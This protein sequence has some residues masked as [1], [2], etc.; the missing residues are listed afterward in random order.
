MKK[1]IYALLTIVMVLGISLINAPK[2]VSADDT[3]LTNNLSSVALGVWSKGTEVNINLKAA[4]APSGLTLLARGV[5]IT[6]GG[7][8]CHPLNGGPFGWT[9]DIRQLVNG[10][11]VKLATTDKNMPTFEGVVTSCAKAPAAGTYALF[12]F[13]DIKKAPGYTFN[14]N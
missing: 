6:A 10:K 8:I 7:T 2:T 13:F 9:G 12:G 1:L 3:I 4:P 5:K 11:W 14:Q